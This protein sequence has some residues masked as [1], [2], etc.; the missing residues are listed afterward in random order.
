MR[1]RV[2]GG[3]VTSAPIVAPSKEVGGGGARSDEDEIEEDGDEVE[4]MAGMNVIRWD[5]AL[6][7]AIV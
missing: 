4:S 2:R 1:K 3:T 7:F 5:I 6:H